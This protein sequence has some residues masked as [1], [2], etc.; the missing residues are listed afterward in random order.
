M[1]IPEYAFNEGTLAYY[2][3]I[4]EFDK[5]IIGSERSA[6][7]NDPLAHHYI[8]RVAVIKKAYPE[9]SVDECRAFLEDKLSWIGPK[10]DLINYI[11]DKRNK[12]FAEKFFEKFNVVDFTYER[13]PNR[14]L[15]E[16]LTRER[17]FRWVQF[18]GVWHGVCLCV[19]E[20]A[21]KK[22]FRV[23]LPFE[24]ATTFRVYAVDSASAWAQ[25]R[26]IATKE[27]SGDAILKEERDYNYTLG[28]VEL[29]Q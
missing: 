20:G 23:T 28:V 6:L 14:E 24:G 15:F 18:A 9:K 5:M 3:E 19:D 7:N 11:C 26:A 27:S 22:A 10:H 29:E 2:R 13:I 25:A 1:N 21:P 16:F 4:A 17:G 8:G 12:E